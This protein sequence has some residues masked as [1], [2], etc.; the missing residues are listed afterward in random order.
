MTIT[1]LREGERLSEFIEFP[2]TVYRDD[3]LWVPPLREQV[4]HQLSGASVFSRYGRTQLFMCES[5]GRVAGRIA[6]LVNTRLRDR[7]DRVIGQLGFFECLDD[8]AAASD[9]VE[10]GLEWLRAQGAR[11]VLAPINGGAHRTHRLQT[12]GFD[13]QPFLFEPRNPPYYP[14]L[15]ERC[16]FTVIHRWFSYEMTRAQAASRLHQFEHVMGR[17][18]PHGHIEE[19]RPEQTLETLTRIYRLL[20]GCWTGHIGYSSLDFEEFAEVFGGPL[21][22]M[23]SGNISVFVRNERDSGLAFVYPDYVADM[24]A[25]QGHADCWGQWLGRSTP[26]SP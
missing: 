3:P 23:G 14:A 5:Q 10:A 19:L 20:D 15:L 9:L 11:E 12:R 24:R 22:I 21:S 13:R 8:P 18:P 25:L 1:A 26:D 17:R 16:G 4:F 7:N 2:W 6:A